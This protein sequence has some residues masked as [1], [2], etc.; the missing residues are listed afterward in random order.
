[1]YILYIIYILN[2]ILNVIFIKLLCKKN[3][4]NKMDYINK[5]QTCFGFNR[6]YPS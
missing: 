4:N 1:M 3:N 6:F 2:G 5:D